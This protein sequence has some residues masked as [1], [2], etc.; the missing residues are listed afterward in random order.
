MLLNL[1]VDILCNNVCKY[2]ETPFIVSE[3]SVVSIY[4]N[5]TLKHYVALSV[6]SKR[7]RL[8][9]PKTWRNVYKLELKEVPRL[10]NLDIIP[11]SCNILTIKRCKYLKSISLSQFVSWLEERIF[12]IVLSNLSKLRC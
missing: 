3:L 6:T 7:L 8:T 11:E 12:P 4:I 2:F 10:K 5:Q 9:I 1:P